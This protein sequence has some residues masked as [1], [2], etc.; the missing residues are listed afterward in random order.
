M[1]LNKGKHYPSIIYDFK[2]SYANGFNSASSIKFK[3][4][5]FVILFQYIELHSLD[6]SIHFIFLTFV[7]YIYF[8]LNSNFFIH[9]SLTLTP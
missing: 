6:F 4:I 1:M 9:I 2:K 7:I 5:I 3:A 8:I